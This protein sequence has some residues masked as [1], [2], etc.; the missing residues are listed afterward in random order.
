MRYEGD[1][2]RPP[3][4]AY[5]L[6]IQVTIGCTWNRCKFCNM[7]K[8]KKFR[9]R[10]IEEVRQDLREAS[11]YADRYDK[12]FLCDGN[13]FAL[14]ASKMA[15]ILTSIR[16]LFPKIKGV[17]SYCRS[18][19][20][21]LK[22]PEELKMLRELGLDMVYI[23][24]ETGSDKILDFYNKGETS[25]DMIKA[26][27]MLRAAGI[28][29][30]ISIMAG[31]GGEDGWEEHML[32]TAHVLN[33]MQPEYVGMLVMSLS[34]DGG[35]PP[36]E[37]SGGPVKTPPPKQVLKEMRLLIEHLDQENCYFTSA[38]ISNYV[39]VKG[40]LPQDKQGLLSLIDSILASVA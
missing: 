25:A 16:E 7:Y 10:D 22:T 39:Y 12:I 37:M 32:E 24:L 36:K 9:V 29:Q 18:K 19:D 20:V 5:S 26:A 2:Y 34:P 23:G 1:I 4:E 31:M 27:E 35:I 14:K 30:S 17:R 21:L 13:A 8:E 3:S 33:R 6:L 11:R 40:H 15:E 28:K 38:H